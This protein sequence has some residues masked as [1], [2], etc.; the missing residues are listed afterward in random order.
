MV[1]TTR[2]EFLTFTVS[3]GWE[4]VTDNK[5]RG[6]LPKPLWEAPENRYWISM[7]SEL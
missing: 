1:G 3:T 2:L 5:G 7:K 4:A 6:W